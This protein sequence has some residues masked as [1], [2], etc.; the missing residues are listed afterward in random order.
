MHQLVSIAKIAKK[1]ERRKILGDYLK[2]RVGDD[3]S[4]LFVGNQH[5]LCIRFLFDNQIT[6]LDTGIIDD[7]D[8]TEIIA[9]MFGYEPRQWEKKNIRLLMSN[10]RA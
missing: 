2:K 3:V 7:T 5:R 4:S 8:Q 9:E 6:P 10:I 1:G